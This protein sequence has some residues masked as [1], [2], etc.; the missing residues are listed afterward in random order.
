MTPAENN[1]P[2]L[3]KALGLRDLV[4]LN[5]ACVVGLSSLTQ[6]AQFGWA[7]FPLWI[8][9]MICYLIPS[10][11]MVSDLNARVPGEGGFY[12]W[13]KKAFGE[14]H[15]FVAAWCYWLSNIVWFPAILLTIVLSGLYIFGDDYLY[16]KENFWVAGVI[17]WAVLWF[18]I[19]LN[20]Y[21][22]KFGKW[23]QNIGAISL[24]ILFL[25]LLIVAIYY[26]I[27]YGS[28]QPFSS[29]KLIPDF[30][31]FGILPFFAAITFSFGGLELSSVMSG[32]IRNP[33]RN[34]VRSIII[35]GIIIS[36]LYC[37]GTFSLLS[38][39]PQGE[40]NIVDGI[41][42]TFFVLNEKTSWPFLGVIGAILV[43]ISTLGLFASWTTGTARLPFVIG[44]DKYLPAALGKIHPKYGTPYISLLVQGV[45]ISILLG[46][47]ISGT[48]VQDAYSFLYDMS[49][50]LYFIPFLYMFASLLKHNV[51]NTG[52]KGGVPLFERYKISVWIVSILGLMV[53]LLSVALA[54]IPSEIVTNKPLFIIK[55]VGT[56]VTLIAIGLLFYYLKR[57]KS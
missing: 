34:I 9:A 5:I 56:T 40:L 42:Q 7:S 18:T 52:G 10:G 30:S 55:I 50:L 46:I 26:V 36:I 3:K 22:L 19:I 25:L 31:D 35:S 20:I 32:E 2:K 41:A 28:A 15:G 45:I 48:L 17:S 14:W 8:L 11:L 1:P 24:W 43:T 21:G 37:V 39:I 33:K 12:N 23:I 29:E 44:L 51:R 27:N 54:V 38:V 13:T 16:L 53:I 49:V 6:A 47:A 4:L 57:R